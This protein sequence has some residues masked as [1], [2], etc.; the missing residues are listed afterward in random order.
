[1]SHNSPFVTD[2][3]LTVVYV[4]LT[5]IMVYSTRMER[6]P[7]QFWSGVLTVLCTVLM[8]M[9]GCSAYLDLVRK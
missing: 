6:G 7:G 2:A 3:V 9:F 5:P 1:M 8:F 4:I